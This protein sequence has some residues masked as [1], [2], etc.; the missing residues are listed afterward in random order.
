MGVYGKSRGEDRSQV[1]LMTPPTQLTAKI[2]PRAHSK[3]FFENAVI[4]LT[5]QSFRNLKDYI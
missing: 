4:S 5:P 2:S 1:I 3:W